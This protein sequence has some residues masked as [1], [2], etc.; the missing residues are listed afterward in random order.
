[1]IY[2][3]KGNIVT[4]IRQYC[5]GIMMMFENGEDN[6][7]PKPVSSIPGPDSQRVISPD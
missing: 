5:L 2:I 4:G 1:M 7:H 3:Q 6:D